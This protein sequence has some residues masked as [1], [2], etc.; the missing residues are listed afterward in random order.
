MLALRWLLYTEHHAIN[1]AVIEDH[2]SYSD[3]RVCEVITNI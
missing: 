3:D 1:D 2:D